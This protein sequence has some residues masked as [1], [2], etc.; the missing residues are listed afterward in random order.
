MKIIL[1]VTEWFNEFN[2]LNLVY[3]IKDGLPF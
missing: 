1:N 3:S 2:E